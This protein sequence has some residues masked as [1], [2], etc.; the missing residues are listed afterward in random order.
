MVVRNQR[1]QRFV[2][3][4]LLGDGSVRW[5]LESPGWIWGAPSSAPEKSSFCVSRLPQVA[6][7]IPFVGTTGRVAS[8]VTFQWEQEQECRA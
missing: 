3:G 7:K 4:V 5:G 8:N 6:A 2:L 1:P